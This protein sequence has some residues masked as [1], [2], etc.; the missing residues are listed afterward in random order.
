MKDKDRHVSIP[1]PNAPCVLLPRV[2][3]RSEE[4][5]CLIRWI[6]VV[7]QRTTHCFIPPRSFWNQLSGPDGI[8]G[9]V[10]LGG[11][12]PR[13]SL[14]AARDSQCLSYA[15][16]RHTCRLKLIQVA[17]MISLWNKMRARPSEWY[18]KNSN[19]CSLSL[20]FMSSYEHFQVLSDRNPKFRQQPDVGIT[21]NNNKDY[22]VYKTHSVAV[23][24]L[25][26][27]LWS[28]L[29]GFFRETDVIYLCLQAFYIEIFSEEG[30][31]IG[32]CYALPSSLS[33]S[34]GYSQLPFI[35]SSGRP[36][37]QISG[38]HWQHIEYCF[39]F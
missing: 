31:R 30:K 24:F 4:H 17:H 29:A 5:I 33:D 16:G 7:S 39:L 3:W 19:Y 11:K 15:P 20:S 12:Q 18:W 35:N 10:N 9:L 23:E 34:C 22:V 21:F 13:T 27:L 26:R 6:A 14:L 8:E 25:V 1:S 28:L 2:S 36:I 37:G 38:R 32:A